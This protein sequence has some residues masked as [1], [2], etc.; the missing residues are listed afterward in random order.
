MGRPNMMWRAKID[1][2]QHCKEES[3]CFD[4]CGI[5]QNC[6]DCRRECLDKNQGKGKKMGQKCNQACSLLGSCP[7]PSA[8]TEEC[9]TCKK[10][11]KTTILAPCEE[12]CGKFC[13]IHSKQNDKKK[14]KE[15]TLKN[16]T[17]NGKEIMARERGLMKKSLHE[18]LQTCYETSKC[19]DKCSANKTCMD[20]KKSCWGSERPKGRGAAK[21]CNKKCK[22]ENQ[23]PKNNPW[24]LRKG[25]VKCRKGCKKSILKP[26]HKA[27]G[28]FCWVKSKSY[29]VEKCVSCT[30][31]KCVGVDVDG[32]LED[33]PSDF[34]MKSV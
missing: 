11:C 30:S 12:T 34:S 9:K 22:K 21:R 24:K 2:L 4:L 26:C 8:F 7:K 23:C 29:D 18:A 13:T 25:C 33:G 14:C 1:E 27:C 17:P 16:C 31:E 32:E 19:E 28:E 20:C 10:T 5:D 3:G 6:L 15:C